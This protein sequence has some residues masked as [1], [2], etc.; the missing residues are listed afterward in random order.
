MM[1]EWD[2]DITFAQA[3]AS[4]EFT[5]GSIVLAESDRHLR[6]SQLLSLIG[7]NDA[8]KGTD[9][10]NARIAATAAYVAQCEECR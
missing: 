1:T 5:P 4:G 6:N 2:Y 7:L 10:D 8:A 9:A 3:R